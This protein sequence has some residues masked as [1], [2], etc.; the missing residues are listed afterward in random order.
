[1]KDIGYNLLRRRALLVVFLTIFF[2]ISISA[3]LISVKA[4]T[5]TWLSNPTFDTSDEWFYQF[6]SEGDNSD[7]NAD[8]SN[9]TANF[10]VLG[11]AGTITPVSGIINNSKS[12]M[13][14]KQYKNDIFQFPDTANIGSEGIYVRHRW[15]DD[16]NQF[17]SV[18]FRKNV[19]M[20]IDM[21][22]YNIT[23]VN[24]NILFNASVNSNVDTPNDS[25]DWTYFGT[26]DYIVFYALIS[27]IYY[28]EPYYVAKNKTRYLG[29]NS[30]EFI[31][32]ND[33]LLFTFNENVII[34]A[35]NKAFEKDPDHSNFS[36][37]LGIDI[38]S[39]DNIQTSDPDYFDDLYIKT[40]NLTI[41]YKK[42]IDEY[43]TI[44]WNQ[45]ASK[46]SGDDIIISKAIFSFNY[47]I[48]KIWPEIAP[49]SEIRFYVNNKLFSTG[50]IKL[51][52]FQES[53]EETDEFDV[54]GFIE[55][56]VNITI[57]IQL[58]LKDSFELE[59]IYS[60]SIDNV[61]LRI[62][63]ISPGYDWT[64]II[65]SLIFG[66][67]F[68]ISIFIAYQKYYKYPKKIRKLRKFRRKVRKGKSI[69]KLEFNKKEE[70]IKNLLINK[71]K[72]L[73]LMIIILIFSSFLL[74]FYINSSI[75]ILNKNQQNYSINMLSSDINDK[76]LIKN[77]NFNT[78]EYWNFTFGNRGDPSVLIS[79]F[80][81]NTANINVLGEKKEI[82]LVSGI[83]NQT[84]FSQ[85]WRIY[86]NSNYLP[87]D[88]AVINGSGCYVWHTLDEA[89]S[90]GQIHNFPSVHFKKNI[91]I[92][93][94]MSLY[95]ITSVNLDILINASV[96]GN[97]DAVNDTV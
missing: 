82:D 55:K 70:I 8:I 73:A 45:E 91:S 37:T 53:F 24:L 13:G 38:Y 77:P 90:G 4:K 48:N 65:I 57:S 20:N 27:D 88:Y 63:L 80:N 49:L 84:Q 29:Q 42:N 46:I 79:S 61:N 78:S 16:P 62:D 14:W 40:F 83:P 35:L 2:M 47:K 30:P 93:D 1:M 69:N 41:S 5:Y 26:G 68:L 9:G 50:N 43:T 6:G 39:E 17:P 23:D 15:F 32:I 28:Q 95:K 36:I 85:G 71:K 25:G 21:S 66:I 74:S 3:S 81:N 19:S 92:A 59:E 67:I 86:N 60:I 58:I 18:H 12:S 52:N 7:V 97:V 22:D 51:S 34:E 31:Q 75:F 54:K 76:E 96:N 44:S 72:T 89:E 56:N 94:D 64:P 33:S 10:N 87:P 11:D